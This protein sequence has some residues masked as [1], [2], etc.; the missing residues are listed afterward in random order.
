MTGWMRWSGVLICALLAAAGLHARSSEFREDIVGTPA[1]NIAPEQ[2]AKFL[3]EC[4]PAHAAAQDAPSFYKPD[5]LYQYIDGG[6]DIFLL[7]DFRLLVHQDFRNGDLELTADIYDMGRP[8]D[9]F[10]MYASERSPGYNF[11]PI[12]VEGYRSKGILNFLQDQ[13]YVKLAGFGPGADPLLDQLARALSERIGGSRGLPALLWK[14]PQENRV[15]HS[16][17]YMRKD[18]IGHAFLAP[19]YVVAYAWGPQETKLMISVADD[20]AGAK[21]RLRQLEKHFRESGECVNAADLGE[22]GI[23]ASN[24]F[25][26]RIF[27]R[28]QGRYVVA[29]LNPPDNGAEILKKTAQSLP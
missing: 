21:A 6:A 10:G 24:S 11:V 2:L 14:L 7:Y 5:N 13:Y 27:A 20:A 4:L 22:D 3:R 16:E 23:R 28:T 8:E 1:S 17:Q 26:G 15:K 29:L 18:P 12:G 19:A 9:A 25:E